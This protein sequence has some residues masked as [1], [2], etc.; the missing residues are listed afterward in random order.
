MKNS[1][2]GITLIALV[3]TII[4]LLILAGVTISAILRKDGAITNANRSAR[5]TAIAD[6]RDEIERTINDVTTTTLIESNDRNL[7]IEI[8]NKLVE[9]ARNGSSYKGIT[10]E[11]SYELAKLIISEN[12][13][14]GAALERK[15]SIETKAAVP[16]ETDVKKSV[17]KEPDILYAAPQTESKASK[18]EEIEIR[19]FKVYYNNELVLIGNLNMASGNFKFVEPGKDILEEAPIKEREPII[20]SKL[21]EAEE[22]KSD[23]KLR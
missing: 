19:Q 9:L 20:D 23:E 12:K 11:Y 3:I 18:V 16:E 6:A 10:Y 8:N 22:A 5:E 15:T 7:A 2:K 14:Y 4:I 1:Q 17:S 13:I 21:E